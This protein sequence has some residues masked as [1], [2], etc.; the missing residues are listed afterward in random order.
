[1]T[2]LLTDTIEFLRNNCLYTY[3]DYCSFYLFVN[4]VNLTFKKLYEH[5]KNN[6]RLLDIFRVHCCK[7]R[8]WK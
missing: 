2:R 4:I 3:I 5:F 8:C 7:Y 6:C 1:M